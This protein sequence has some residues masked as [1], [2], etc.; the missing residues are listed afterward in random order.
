MASLDRLRIQR[1]VRE[2]L[3]PWNDDVPGMTVGIVQDGELILHESAGLASLELGVPIGPETCF[4]IASVSKQFT[5]AAILLLE[6]EGRLSLTDEARTCLPELPEYG[7]KVTVAHLMH[8][9]SGLRD[10]LEIM[11]QGGVDL[12][13]PCSQDD[14]LAGIVRQH[15]LNFAPGSRFLYS[16]TNFLLLGLIVERLTGEPLGQF[17][18]RRIFARLGMTRT[19]MTP[20]PLEPVAGL[21]TGYLPHQSGFRRAAH[22]FPLGGE[23]GL[24]SCVEDLA[25]WDRNY[26]TGLVEVVKGLETQTEF[27]S[28]VTNLYARGLRIDHWRG[29]RTVSHGG[30]WPGYRTEFLRVPSRGCTVIAITNTG[31]ADPAVFAHKVLES[32]LEGSLPPVP[33]APVC[34]ALEPLTGRWIEPRSG[35]TLEIAVD[36]D[37]ALAVT[38]GGATVHPEPAADGR[39]TV[40]HGTILIAIRRLEDG[41]L[42]IEQDAG[43]TAIWHRAV[44]GATLP[45][46]LDGTYQSLEMASLW[47]IGGSE[48]KVEGPLVRGASWTIEPIEG[49]LVRIIVPGI[50]ARAWFDV[51]IT[52]GPGGAVTG[53]LVSSNRLRDV[54]YERLSDQSG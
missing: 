15:T 1:S 52:R 39:L 21:A 35:T 19:R 9:S 25:L 50:L 28:G 5:C 31:A 30:L 47:T 40:T 41:T 16:N 43:H 46:G 11:R 27:S 6:A 36:D 24:V 13:T 22:A 45:E 53:L 18:Q 26:T 29:L 3:N 12:G 10:M 4:R 54:R 37:G 14:L 42:E 7:P 38:A 44:P 17:L 33:A 23:G 51:R 2:L 48:V 32:L 8:N 49:D 34:A 20:H